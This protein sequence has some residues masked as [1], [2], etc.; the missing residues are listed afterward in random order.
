MLDDLAS[1]DALMDRCTFN[2]RLL[3][4]VSAVGTAG[5]RLA[6][7]PY[8]VIKLCTRSKD[9]R[10]MTHPAPHSLNR[11]MVLCLASGSAM[12]VPACV[13]LSRMNPAKLALFALMAA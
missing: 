4:Q 10:T 13:A 9:R 11:L 3:V 2:Q 8:A 12:L 5:L 7:K 6:C 1:G